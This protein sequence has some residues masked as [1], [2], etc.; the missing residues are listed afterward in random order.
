MYGSGVSMHVYV[1]VYICACVCMRVYVYEY[2]YV[3]IYACVCLLTPE[4]DI[5]L[6]RFAKTQVTDGDGAVVVLHP[7]HA[8]TNPMGNWSVCVSFSYI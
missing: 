6:D 5:R 1:Y 3:Y 7:H 8:L 2:V 4:V